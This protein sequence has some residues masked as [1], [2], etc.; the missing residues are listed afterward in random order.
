M[1][2]ETLV[3]APGE[4]IAVESGFLRGHGTYAE[5]GV[6]VSSLAGVVERVNRL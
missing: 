6:L 5:A 2:E 4:D 3:V 1:A